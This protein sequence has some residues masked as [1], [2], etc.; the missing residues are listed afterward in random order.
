MNWL[1]LVAIATLLDS[2]RIFIDNYTSDYYFKGKDAVSQKFF[3][4]YA[5]LI[6]AI[7]ILIIHSGDIFSTSI[8]TILLLI[9]S[10]FMHGISGIPYFKALELDDS[11]NLGIFIQMAPILYLVLGCLFLGE[12]FS[13]WQLVAIAV[14]LL[15]PI[16]IVATTRK[17]SRKIRLRAVFYSFIYVFIAVVSNLIFVQVSGSGDLSLLPE[18]GLIMVGKSIANLTIVYSIPKLRRRFKYVA[19]TSHYKVLRPMICNHLIGFIKEFAYRGALIAA[20]AVAI[21]SAA[22]DSVTPVVI[23]F[24]GIVLSII[25]PNFGREKLNRKNVIVHLIATILVVT[26]IIILQF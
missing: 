9:L 18:V 10:G 16:L 8:T 26:G 12:S 6:T 2:A 11:T 3:Y 1:V 7:P 19:K 4:G 23:F 20:P 22:S 5:I 13:A 15:A 14:I 24:M 21:A 17:R 25:W